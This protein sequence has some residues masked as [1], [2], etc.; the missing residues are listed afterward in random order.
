MGL[1]RVSQVKERLELTPLFPIITVAGT[2]GKGSTCAMLE[3]IYHEA[4]YR[5]ACYS[6]P[7][8][9]RYNER[10]RV[11]CENADDE[12]IVLAFET[13]EA[14]RQDTQLTYFEYG[15]L[16]AMR[17]FM[18]ADVDVAI[19]EVGLGGRL[20]AV[21]AFE[22]SCSIVTSIDLDHIEFLGNSRE[23]I[24]FEKAGIFR[25]NIAAIYGDTAPPVSMLQHAKEVGAPLNL[26]TKD[27]NGELNAELN[28]NSWVY[29]GPQLK[30]A[31][32]P[33]PA[34]FGSFQLSNAA[35]A[36]TAIN[37][38]QSRLPVNDAAIV[39][40]LENVKL[41]GRFQSFATTPPVILDVAHNPHAAQ[42][43]A[44]SLHSSRIAGRTL[45]VFSMLADKDIAGV[46]KAIGNE[47]NGWYVAN[48]ANVRG[49]PAD[50]LAD[51]IRLEHPETTI[52]AFDSVTDAYHQA[53]LEA[54]ENDRIV[55]MGSFFT[56]AEIMPYLP[57]ST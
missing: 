30:I 9:L 48:I 20:D 49:A 46:I 13:V 6:S 11:G 42:A 19:L 41:A 54:H 36:I 29:H 21:N 37:E 45:A 23:S 50:Q 39:A 10:I 12:D 15:T 2:N 44:A 31:D 22:P 47:I 34:L 57:K 35:C 24:G 51:A 1:E 26:I 52:V 33:L 55:V 27:F 14:A 5:V 28:G 8:L 4:G 17:H 7:H 43:L 40:G 16:A 3:R 56:V 53:C 32:L 18:D 25:N 38:L